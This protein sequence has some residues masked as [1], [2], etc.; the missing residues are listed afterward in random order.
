MKYAATSSNADVFKC[1]YMRECLRQPQRL[2]E[3]ACVVKVY[4]HFY[5]LIRKCAF[6]IEV[7][8]EPQN[9]N[10]YMPCYRLAVMMGLPRH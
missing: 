6:C 8:V 7:C 1:V 9:R 2:G 10:K 5:L 3:I 4:F